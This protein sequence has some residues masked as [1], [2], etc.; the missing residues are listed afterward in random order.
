[1]PRRNGTG[2]MGYGRATGRG[3]GFCTGAYPRRYGAGIGQRFGRGIG[4][5]GLYKGFGGYIDDEVDFSSSEKEWLLNQKE[6]LERELK[7]INHDLEN[8]NEE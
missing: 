8:L 2:P 4:C 6:F 5:R 7:T 3:F 1:M